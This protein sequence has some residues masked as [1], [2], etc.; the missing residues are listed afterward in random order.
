[1]TENKKYPF[2]FYLLTLLIP[3]LFF[4]LLE[5]GLRVASYGEVVPQWVQPSK[6][7]PDYLMLN[8]EIARRYFRNLRRPPTPHYDGFRKNKSDKT[9]RVFIMGGSSAAG[10]PYP[11]NGAFS[12]M[13]SRYLKIQYPLAHIEV[14]NIALSATNSY[15]IRDL[16]PGVLEKQPDLV[17]IYAGHNEY[18]GAL[19]AGSSEFWGSSTFVVNF[20]LATQDIRTMQLLR[21]IIFGIRGWFSQES[22]AREDA[23][24]MARMV[25]KQLIPLYSQTYQNGISQFR[26]N[27][28]DIL[29]WAGD[30]NVPVILGN[31]TSNMKDQPPFESIAEDSLPAAK[32]IYDRAELEYRSGS[33]Q[34][35]RDLYAKA[36]ELDALR[37]RAPN[38]INETIAELAHKFQLPLVDIDSVF[39]ANSPHYIVDNTLM[40]DHLHPN[41]KGIGLTG[42]AFIRMMELRGLVPLKSDRIYP[43]SEAVDVAQSWRL[44]RLDS[45]YTE[46]RLAY[47]RG[48]WPFTPLGKPNVSM[49][50]YKPA[51][52]IDDLA[53]RMLTDE[54]NWEN[55]HVR[56]AMWYK[57]KQEEFN[58]IGEMRALIEVMPFNETPYKILIDG[59]IE[60]Q[61]YDQA[62]VFLKRLHNQNPGAYHYK[63]QGILSLY[64]KQ[65]QKAKEF[66][67]TARGLDANDAQ[68]LYNLCGVHIHF[69][70][71]EQALRAV[72]ACLQLEPD[73]PGA[74]R[75]FNDLKKIV[76]K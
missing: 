65:Y 31:L 14:I 10:F 68:L 33:Y 66:L 8:P 25:G 45:T 43:V 50:N 49:Q 61:S 7:F 16:F 39:R 41:L 67:L 28:S 52:F 47:L 53:Y 59:L 29:S 75:T 21:N 58:F 73:F 6:D 57:E 12:H 19:G 5:M 76:A 64:T 46:L 13:I 38:G 20:M 37:F 55:A 3:V 74:K 54:I 9:Y 18:Y 56:A 62:M 63:W 11:V 32:E 44:T 35:A 27:L 40:T 15:T 34:K 70:E 51:D 48:G 17:I 26:D 36:R 42:A 30:Q 60:L 71:Y 24:L 23:T 2:Y 72:S 4:V 69:R 22:E 1:M